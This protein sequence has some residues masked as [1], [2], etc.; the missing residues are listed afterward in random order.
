MAIRDKDALASCLEQQQKGE[1]RQDQCELHSQASSE[2]SVTMEEAQPKTVD[3]TKE[4]QYQGQEVM[5][6]TQD[7]RKQMD[8]KL[9]EITAQAQSEKDWM[10]GSENVYDMDPMLIKSPLQLVS[11]E[12]ENLTEIQMPGLGS[13]FPNSTSPPDVDSSIFQVSSHVLSPSHTLPIRIPTLGEKRL[14]N[15]EPEDSGFGTKA[16]KSGNPRAKTTTALLKKRALG[17]G[18]SF[19]PGAAVPEGGWSLRPGVASRE[20]LASYVRAASEPGSSLSGRPELQAWS[21]VRERAESQPGSSVRERL[22]LQ[23]WSSI[24]GATSLRPRSRVRGHRHTEPRGTDDDFWG[25]TGPVA[26][27]VVDRERNLYRVQFP[28]AGSYHCPNIGL[29]FVVTKAVTIKIEFCTWSQYLYE[30]PLLNSHIVAGPLFD[31]KAEQGAVATV[32]LPHFVP[33]QEGKVDTSLFHVAHFQEEGMILETPARV[34]QH[35]AVLENPSFSP[36][37]ILVRMIPTIGHFIPITSI[38]LIYYHLNLKEVTLHLYLIPNDCTIR[39]AID[40]E[41]MK[42]QFVRIHKP[43]PVDCLYVGSRYIVSA[44]KEL[45]IIPKCSNLLSNGVHS[46]AVHYLSAKDSQSLMWCTRS[47]KY[48]V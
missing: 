24:K 48:G 5:D 1:V 23:A 11:S 36:V 27:E 41:E 37:G 4:A 16:L 33:L 18:P 39:K 28:M 9:Q 47:R 8:L 40:E 6:P 14:I 43:P 38:T 42:F 17:E 10:L 30:T 29:C 25:P 35:Y 46:K 26:T 45:K 12:L 32:Y 15:W 44:S 21:R 22:E 7:K 20:T 3:G 13:S 34:E 31:I 19:R 2:S